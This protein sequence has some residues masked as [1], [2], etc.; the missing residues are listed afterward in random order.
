MAVLLAVAVVVRL[1]QGASTAATGV[2]LLLAVGCAAAWVVR[3][4]LLASIRGRAYLG[5]ATMAVASTTIMLL[6]LEGVLRV[7]GMRATY[8]ERN[9]N[10][11]YRSVYTYDQPVW[12]HTF[13][14]NRTQRE[15]RTEFT[16]IRKTNSLGLP[17]VEV[18]VEKP[19]GEYRLLA[20][21][22]SFTE[23]V[24]AD[25]AET[26]VR[27]VEGEL[28]PLSDGRVLR[29]IDAGVGGSDVLLEYVLLRDKLAPF[30]PDIV[31]VVVNN[32][33]VADVMTRG[34]M[35]RFRPDGRAFA[36]RG[37]WW[38]WL[39]GI[40]FITRHVVHDVLG[41]SWLLLTPAQQA[42]AEAEARAHLASGIDALATLSR[43]IGAQ[44][45]VVFHPM[46]GEVQDG[47]YEAAFR[48]LVE[49]VKASRPTQAIDLLARY[50]SEG[51][52]TP[53]TSGD[54]Y[55]P[56]DRHHNAR[57]YRLM[58]K[59]IARELREHGLVPTDR[60]P[61]AVDAP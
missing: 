36:N 6:A 40:S 46:Q 25:Y 33:D 20:L 8:S 27:V 23:G 26:W 24:G 16:Q 21:G 32:S 22:D 44:F 48:P 3:T 2:L 34:G 19:V 12:Y 5:P 15:V 14:R 41:R 45:A 43:Q 51:V 42:D 7:A 55:W 60:S 11:V 9:G 1:R 58:G 50:Q 53:V 49:S 39:Y 59:A 29:A 28:S 4:L 57:G 13:G 35:E 38:D 56:V 17:E 31:V 10:P 54:Y 47:L 18:P 61:R 52:L 37:P 30:R